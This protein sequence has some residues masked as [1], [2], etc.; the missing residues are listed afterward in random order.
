MSSGYWVAQ[1]RYMGP[2]VRWVVSSMSPRDRG[3][4]MDQVAWLRPMCPP[5]RIGP[6]QYRGWCLD[7]RPWSTWRTW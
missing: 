1:P 4:S 2:F 7:S 3:S 5:K 6:L